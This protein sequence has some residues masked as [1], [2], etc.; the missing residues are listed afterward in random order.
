MDDSQLMTVYEWID[1]I[2]LSREK[3]N[4]TIDFSD[5]VLAAEILKHYYPKLVELHNYPSTF[6]T[7][8]KLSNWNTLCIKVLKKINL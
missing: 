8:Q 4:M 5:G 6:N 7:K 3:K 2:P 1:S